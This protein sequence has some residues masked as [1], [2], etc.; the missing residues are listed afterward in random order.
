MERRAEHILFLG[1]KAY[2]DEGDYEAYLTRNGGSCNAHTGMEDTPFY[3]DVGAEH[4]HGALERFSH[5]FRTPLLSAGRL[6]REVEAVNAEHIA[7]RGSDTWRL[8]QLIETFS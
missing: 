6:D 5:F 7:N 8:F 2:P 4:L 3:F 1:T